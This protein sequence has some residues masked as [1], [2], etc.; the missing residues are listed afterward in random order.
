MSEQNEQSQTIPD[1]VTDPAQPQGESGND[2][3]PNAEAAKY[4]HRLRAAEAERDALAARLDARDRADIDKLAADRLADVSDLWTATSLDAM[5][6][7]DGMID[8]EKAAAEIEALLAAKPHYAKPVADPPVDLH[9]GQRMTAE[10]P[11][12]SIGAAIKQSLGG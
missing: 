1:A 11:R 12:P 10:P 9:Q 5:R 6:S 8:M 7:E 3:S 4:R 2:R